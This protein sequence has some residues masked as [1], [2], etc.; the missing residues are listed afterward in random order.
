MR[1]KEIEE[2][3]KEDVHELGER[4]D[5]INR[6]DGNL[7]TFVINRHINY[8]NICVARCPLCAFYRELGDKEAYFMSV[9]EVLEQVG[10]AVKMGATELHIVGSL[11]LAMNIGYFENIF[12]QI[13][14]RFPGVCINTA[15]EIYFRACRTA[16][17]SRY[18]S[19]QAPGA[20]G[21][22]WWVCILHSSSISS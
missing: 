20:A 6:E 15:T 16:G 1:R 7:V 19:S 9:E 17:G 11:N 22:D 3:F 5:R 2:L 12:T 21:E 14:M 4:A 18:P 10:D 13:R 8:T